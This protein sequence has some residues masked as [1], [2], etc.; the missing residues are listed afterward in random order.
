VIDTTGWVS[1]FYKK[2]LE[3][4]VERVIERDIL[5]YASHELISEFKELVTLA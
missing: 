4:F 3:E 5:I 1:I 2:A